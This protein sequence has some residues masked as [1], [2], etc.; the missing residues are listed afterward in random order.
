MTEPV[1]LSDRL[2]VSTVSVT[3]VETGVLSAT[4]FSK[5]PPLTSVIALVIGAWPVNASFGAVVVAVPVVWPTPMV[6]V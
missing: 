1:A 4:R 2:V 5:L 3:L 6:M